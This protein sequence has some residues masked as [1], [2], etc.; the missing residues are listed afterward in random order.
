M[1]KTEIFMFEP[2]DKKMVM[3]NILQ[4]NTQ[5]IYFIDTQ[6]HHNRVNGRKTLDQYRPIDVLDSIDFDF[7]R[8]HTFL[9]KILTS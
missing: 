8:T 7:V 6:R 2:V 3:H 5:N 9:L 4:Q 1:T